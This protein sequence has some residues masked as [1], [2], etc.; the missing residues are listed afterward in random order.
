[1][2]SASFF[3]LFAGAGVGV[4][5]VDH[6]AAKLARCDVLASDFHGCREDLVGRE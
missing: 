4:S 1:M 2:R 5:G 3:A 6:D